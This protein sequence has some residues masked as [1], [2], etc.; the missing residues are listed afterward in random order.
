M[1][2][3]IPPPAVKK[4]RKS[5]TKFRRR[6]D[7]LKLGIAEYAR[8]TATPEDTAYSYSQGRREPLGVHMALLGV[9]LR[10]EGGVETLRAYHESEIAK[11]WEK[12]DDE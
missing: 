11:A 2:D 4:R 9:L 1:G 3:C 12:N 7:N 10:M 5:R 6:L 8:L